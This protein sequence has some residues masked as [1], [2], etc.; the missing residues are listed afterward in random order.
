MI[1]NA[2]ISMDLGAIN[3]ALGRALNKLEA[4]ALL[5]DEPSPDGALSGRLA[6]AIEQVAAEAKDHLMVIRED[7]QSVIAKLLEERAATDE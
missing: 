2:D 5:T 6:S 7:V 1:T 4:I 3:K